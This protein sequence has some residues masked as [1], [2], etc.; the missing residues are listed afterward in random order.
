MRRPG[1]SVRHD[2]SVCN[3]PRS[4]TCPE[5]ALMSLKDLSSPALL[6][7]LIAACAAAYAA[8]DVAPG[9][10]DKN[11][12][13][14]KPVYADTPETFAEQSRRIVSEMQQAGRYEYITASDKRTVERL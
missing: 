1:K 2:A 12:V 3:P 5:N 13:V 8:E 7:L 4:T 9:Q 11:G 10:P 6:A 14:Q